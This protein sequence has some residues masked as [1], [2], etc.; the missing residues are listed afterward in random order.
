[1]QEITGHHLVIVVLHQYDS[2]NVTRIAIA[3]TAMPG[4]SQRTARVR[5]AASHAPFAIVH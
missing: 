1:M 2:Y 5:R 3:V 4:G